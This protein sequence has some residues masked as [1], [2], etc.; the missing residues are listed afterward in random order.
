M[1]ELSSDLAQTVLGEVKVT[2]RAPRVQP[3]GL[4]RL[5]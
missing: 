1:K 4:L 5:N 3:P 2:A